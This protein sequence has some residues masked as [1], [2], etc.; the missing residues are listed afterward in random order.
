[1]SMKKSTAD[2]VLDAVGTLAVFAPMFLTGAPAWVLGLCAAVAYATG[3]AAT[4]GVPF[5]TKPSIQARL[6][7]DNEDPR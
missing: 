1:M 5:R 2:K 7:E 3:K 6:G 4:P